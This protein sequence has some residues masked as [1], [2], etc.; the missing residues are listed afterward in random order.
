L[1]FVYIFIGS[2]WL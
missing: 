1:T 2:K